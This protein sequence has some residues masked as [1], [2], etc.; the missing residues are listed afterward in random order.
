[1]FAQVKDADSFIH[2][3][4]E[5]FSPLECQSHFITED[6][7]EEGFFTISFVVL[8]TVST[9]SLFKEIFP[10]LL[11]TTLFVVLVFGFY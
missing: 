10:A 9:T 1:M 5:R 7:K 6:I 3:L 4:E 11:F 2:E 8:A